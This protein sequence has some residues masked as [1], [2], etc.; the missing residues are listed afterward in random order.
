MMLVHIEITAG[1]HVEVKR[2][3]ARNQ[4][5]HVVEEADSRGDARLSAPIEI[6]PQADVRL[7]GL[8]MNLTVRGMIS[9]L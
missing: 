3:V 4:L 5:E 1:V 6:Q 8:A 9:S 2:A 7:V